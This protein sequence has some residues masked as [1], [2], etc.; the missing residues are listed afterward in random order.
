MPKVV[1]MKSFGRMTS[2]LP[3][4]TTYVGRGSR[5][6]NRY[7]VGSHEAWAC[8]EGCYEL[9]KACGHTSFKHISTNY[10]RE[11]TIILYMDYFD[12]TG[13]DQYLET[14]RGKDLACWCAP[15]DC[16][17]DYLLMLA[18]APKD[19]EP[20]LDLSSLLEGLF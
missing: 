16:H 20:D 13:L 4:N 2:L 18:N 1:N 10:T 12:G 5:W 11:E 14:L 15:L 8:I 7:Y 6:G 19:P 3:P 9:G 17:A